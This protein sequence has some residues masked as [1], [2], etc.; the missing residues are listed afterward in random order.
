MIMIDMKMPKCCIGCPIL[1]ESAWW[2]TYCPFVCEEN[3]INI[4]ERTDR[5][6]E[7]PLKEIEESEDYVKRSSITEVLNKMDRYVADELTLCDTERRFPKNEVFIVDDVYEEIVEQLPSVTPAE[8]E[9]HWTNEGFCGDYICSVC[10]NEIDSDVPNMRGFN[11]EL[12][13]YCPNCG[14]KM[15]EISISSEEVAAND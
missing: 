12:P 11:F 15:S 2:G 1:R 6:S 13:K 8:K 5:P 3:N 10:K 9:G 7:C 4:K 14:A